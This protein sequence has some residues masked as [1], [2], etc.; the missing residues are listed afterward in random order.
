MLLLAL[1]LLA[2]LLLALLLLA[3]LWVKTCDVDLAI[4]GGGHDYAESRRV[5]LGVG[6]S[7][8]FDAALRPRRHDPAFHPLGEQ[9]P[10]VP[11]VHPFAIGGQDRV[12]DM[13][14]HSR[15]RAG[16]AADCELR[17]VRLHLS[18]SC[19]GYRA[20]AGQVHR[21]F[22]ARTAAYQAVDGNPGGARVVD[23]DR[24][25]RRP[26]EDLALRADQQ[27][28]AA[29]EVNRRV[30]PARHRAV[31]RDELLA[32]PRVLAQIERP[33][34]GRVGRDFAHARAGEVDAGGAAGHAHVFG[35][36]E[37]DSAVAIVGPYIADAH[38]VARGVDRA[39]VHGDADVAHI[40]IAGDFHHIA[41]VVVGQVA[42]PAAR[43]LQGVE[44]R[45][46]V[47]PL[48][49]RPEHR[50]FL[51]G[52][53]ELQRLIHDR[54]AIAPR[55]QPRDDFG[56]AQSARPVGVD[57]GRVHAGDGVALAGE[58]FPDLR[59]DGGLESVVRP[60]GRL[61]FL[62][63]AFGGGRR[64]VEDRGGGVSVGDVGLIGDPDAPGR[65]SPRHDLGRDPPLVRLDAP[66][67]RCAVVAIDTERPFEAA[68]LKAAAT[69]GS[70]VCSRP[71]YVDDGRSAGF[72]RAAI[73]RDDGV[74]APRRLDLPRLGECDPAFRVAGN[75]VDEGEDARAAPG[76]QR[77]VLADIHGD[78]PG[79]EGR[80]FDRRPPAAFGRLDPPAGHVDGD[81]ARVSD[82]VLLADRRQD[83]HLPPGDDIARRML[84][85]DVPPGGS[86]LAGD[87]AEARSADIRA[88]GDVDRA[89]AAV[90]DVD[91]GAARVGQPHIVPDIGVMV[92]GAVDRER[93]A[94][95]DRD[96]A[97]TS[98]VHIDAVGLRVDGG[99]VFDTAGR[100]ADYVGFDENAGARRSRCGD[101]AAGGDDLDVGAARE[102]HL[103]GGATCVG[104]PGAADPG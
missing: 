94:V 82:R 103:L 89:G 16:G 20:A 78:R 33:A 92:V 26:G 98:G 49:Q 45:R 14:R 15:A 65:L 64:A 101:R 5:A 58:R 1:L 66:E 3:L 69:G 80:G 81:V 46:R 34:P 85:R 102:R 7:R 91:A 99:G 50:R 55:C 53:G 77:R 35:H 9:L 57:V 11:L 36:G 48:H 27:R 17:S 4:A 74:D 24:A 87:D 32:Q 104:V 56:V 23:Q 95:H 68:C 6:R 60:V 54:R 12:V 39:P 79:P 71:G 13:D 72:R 10:R 100:G 44:G 25:A 37:V 61:L 2:L 90:D 43:R 52:E 67:F 18:G 22:R 47:V 19:D 84:D 75:I 21:R 38:A 96:I 30:G 41:T 42:G 51:I 28:A 70:R 93:A 31:H 59:Q 97:G 40:V 83:A 76:G 8:E 62:G 88:A 29:R 86:G 63:R 73:P